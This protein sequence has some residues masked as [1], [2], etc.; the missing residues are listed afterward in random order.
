MN[1][2]IKVENGQPI[3]HPAFEENII[4]ALGEITSDWEVF[5]RKPIPKLDLYK[6]FDDPQVTYE[7]I[8]GVWTDVFHVR[9]MTDE[10]KNE[11]Q[12]KVKDL[13][14]A[15]PNAS[16]F[17]AWVFDEATCLYQPPIPVPEVGMYRW[18]GLTNSWIEAT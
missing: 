3:N 8:D 18:D 17:T 2:Y 4:E 9:D 6:K 13:W 10:E 15:R 16:N 11:V 12:Q 7:K 14:A 5:V 1:L